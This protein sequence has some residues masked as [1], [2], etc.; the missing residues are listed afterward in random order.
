VAIKSQKNQGLPDPVGNDYVPRIAHRNACGS[1]HFT[2]TST[3]LLPIGDLL[4]TE[5]EHTHRRGSRIQNEQIGIQVKIHIF[6][7][8]KELGRTL[9]LLAQREKR[10]KIQRGLRS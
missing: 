8:P 5:K 6:N 2:G 10:V 7:P 3:R 1:N 4:P 9:L